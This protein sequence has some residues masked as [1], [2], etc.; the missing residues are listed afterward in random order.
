MPGLD[1][2]YECLLHQS[3]LLFCQVY[4]DLHNDF[5]QEIS[6]V[7]GIQERHT[8]P[9]EPEEGVALRAPGNV[10]ERTPGDRWHRDLSSQKGSCKPDDRGRMQVSP[11][12]FEH[13][14]FFYMDDRI[15]VSRRPMV[16]PGLA[17]PGNSQELPVFNTAGD[18]YL[19]LPGFLQGPSPQAGCAG[20]FY[21]LTTPAT[22]RADG[23]IC[24]GAAPDNAGTPDLTGPPAHR[25][26]P[27]GAGLSA[28]TM[29]GRAL[30][31]VRDP[32]GYFRAIER[33]G[34]VREGVLR[35]HFILQDGTIRDSIYYSILDREWLDAK[36][37]LEELL[38]R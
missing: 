34:A 5:Y 13:V 14:V 1:P 30:V 27:Q 12:P 23:N 36:I 6:P 26:V 32:D 21:D 15:E 29:A 19:N 3:L 38:E 33:I 11:L 10:Q 20:P 17:L 22:I 37:R 31:L 16:F 25:A 28:R 18:R 4:R 7:A 8:L 35:N 2:T 9:P 24:H